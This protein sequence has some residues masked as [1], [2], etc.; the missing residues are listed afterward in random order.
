MTAE[1]EII[2]LHLS[3]IHFTYEKNQKL[4]VDADIRNE[5]EL[6]LDRCINKFS[7]N[8]IKSVLIT[9]DI[10]YHAK[11][12]EYERA[13]DWLDKICQKMNLSER[14][15]KCVPGNHDVHIPTVNASET[16]KS[17]RAEINNSNIENIDDILKRK[18][19]DS[20]SG[21]LLLKPFHEYNKFSRKYECNINNKDPWWD[22]DFTLNDGSKLRLRGIN[23]AL[24]SDLLDDKDKKKL[25]I[26]IKEATVSRCE[27]VTI[28][29][30]SHHPTDWIKR[31]DEIESKLNSR[32]RIQLFG[33]KH[34]QTILNANPKRK[35]K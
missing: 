28:G 10:A 30:L 1:K 9:G 33:H 2:F 18:L 15:V 27:G 34:L 14:K 16:I 23:T 4:E 12:D 19:N 35:Q 32:A 11:A 25:I 31:K 3:D 17:I 29:T 13:T 5:V 26:G 21:K 22:Y 8:N 24:V 20:E 6:D 7:F